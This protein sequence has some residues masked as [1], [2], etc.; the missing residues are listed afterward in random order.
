M[1][2]FVTF[3]LGLALSA[4]SL[5]G[6][7]LAQ[8]PASPPQIGPYAT[9]PAASGPTTT[10]DGIIADVHLTQC[11]LTPEARSAPSHGCWAVLQVTSAPAP[12]D[13]QV[14]HGNAVAPTA[15]VTVYVMPGTSITMD[16]G[17]TVPITDLQKGDRV[18]ITY[19]QADFG[20]VATDMT[21][22]ARLGNGVGWGY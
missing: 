17:T 6:P 7:A 13:P 14:D 20:N 16:N 1:T 4:A 2:K 22:R 11:D 3:A 10:I 15:A 9:P 8:T 5:A 12:V 19:E 21:W 18:T